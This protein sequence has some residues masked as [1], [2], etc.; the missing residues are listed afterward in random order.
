MICSHQ[1]TATYYNAQH[2]AR[3]SDV[4]VHKNESCHTYERVM[5]Q[6]GMS[7][8]SQI[9]SRGLDM[10]VPDFKVQVSYV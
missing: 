7:V 9:S 3:G 5:P 6:I 8:M 2:L 10:V 1:N 4:V